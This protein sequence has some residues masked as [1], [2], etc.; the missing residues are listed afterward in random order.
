MIVFNRNKLFFGQESV[1]GQR[2]KWANEQMGKWVIG[3]ASYFYHIT[4]GVLSSRG[5]GKIGTAV[6][7]SPGDRHFE[8]AER[9]EK[10]PRCA[11]VPRKTAS[12]RRALSVKRLFNTPS[13][14][15]G[16]GN[17]GPSFLATDRMA[18]ELGSLVPRN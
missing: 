7:K 12:G 6:A 16:L 4:F 5:L 13:K 14:I 3:F 10:S 18:E 9:V 2:S 1:D 15:G 17:W 11:K 8:R